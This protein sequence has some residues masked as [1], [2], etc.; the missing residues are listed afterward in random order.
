[1][2]RGIS[3][4]VVVSL[5]ATLFSGCRGPAPSGADTWD[6]TKIAPYT[7]LV[8][9]DA[10]NSFE[11]TFNR[12]YLRAV[13]HSVEL[14]DQ[15]ARDAEAAA[16][17]IDGL[18]TS[19]FELVDLLLEKN[20]LDGAKAVALLQ[21][22]AA[23]RAYLD[24]ASQRLGEL[25]EQKSANDYERALSRA[26]MVYLSQVHA[27]SVHEYAVA[28][29]DAACFAPLVSGASMP[30]AVTTKSD[31]IRADFA[32]NLQ[33][34]LDTL[35]VEMDLVSLSIAEIED[36]VSARYDYCVASA[37]EVAADIEARVAHYKASDAPDTRLVARAESDASAFGALF[38]NS[39]GASGGTDTKESSEAALA[40]LRKAAT[41]RTTKD[42]VVP[43]DLVEA[44]VA[45][46][47]ASAAAFKADPA[48][49]ARAAASR[50]VLSGVR[51][52]S[53]LLAAQIETLY[54]FLRTGDSS[55]LK[56]ASGPASATAKG[57][58]GENDKANAVRAL[59]KIREYQQKV[60][61]KLNPKED[62]NALDKLA[63]LLVGSLSVDAI[64]ALLSIPVDE[65]IA[66]RKDKDDLEKYIGDNLKP[67]IRERIGEDWQV[68]VLV[69]AQMDAQVLVDNFKDWFRNTKHQEDFQFTKDEI[70]RLLD[71]IGNRRTP[72]VVKEV[73]VIPVP[74][75]TKGAGAATP[76]PEGTHGVEPTDAP[77]G[78]ET[79][80][81]RLPIEEVAALRWDQPVE[82]LLW[83]VFGW[84]AS[85]GDAA[86][87]D[88]YGWHMDSTGTYRQH[89]KDPEYDL[90]VSS[91]GKGHIW[92]IGTR[93]SK[94]PAK[95]GVHCLLT[96]SQ[97]GSVMECEDFVLFQWG[98]SA[99]P[100]GVEAWVEPFLGVQYRNSGTGRRYLCRNGK[101]QTEYG[102]DGSGAY[103]R[104][105]DTE[106]GALLRTG[107]LREADPDVYDGGKHAAATVVPDA[108]DPGRYGLFVLDGT[109]TQYAVDG[110]VQCRAQFA[111][112]I[113]DGLAEFYYPNGRLRFAMTLENDIRNGPFKVYEQSD[114][115]TTYYYLQA[116]GEYLDGKYEGIWKY[117]QPGDILMATVT[118]KAGRLEGPCAGYNQN[119]TLAISGANQDGNPSED[120]QVYD[121]EGNPTGKGPRLQAHVWTH[122]VDPFFVVIVTDWD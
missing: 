109:Y 56:R 120:W 86:D 22:L 94:D 51:Q 93:P 85:Y 47:P 33:G 115:T 61:D 5:L 102:Y 65:M 80:R 21:G 32:R 108:Y 118:Y 24:A 18:Q 107:N 30:K 90:Y 35:D 66:G 15:L 116:E 19:L 48:G 119:G 52:P 82:Q 29:L 10:T 43:T 1:M 96:F 83:E 121:G 41:F 17:R 31:A 68:Y 46:A 40:A 72:A 23:R 84:K 53:A 104:R 62:A 64:L 113:T 49:F 78:Q 73:V 7:Y 88:S 101:P 76:T 55:S 91:D 97:E 4:L 37:L 95:N 98:S 54:G 70:F 75:P 45:A 60:R 11:R 106:T 26:A 8:A 57:F 58:P 12:L 59:E 87:E 39:P 100:G 122:E 25:R 36:A 6:S 114:D 77:K 44:S 14:A 34:R 92:N 105:F 71:T 27:Q 110:T 42:K 67:Y 81:M 63:G 112:G 69:L 99:R 9:F 111:N 50:E 103:V 3:M 117:Y 28:L 13:D 74:E 89:Y 38:A 79:F 16:G 20:L 2:K